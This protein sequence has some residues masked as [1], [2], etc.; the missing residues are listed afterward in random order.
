MRER[1]EEKRGYTVDYTGSARCVKR[2]AWHAVTESWISL[3]KYKKVGL[4]GQQGFTT[5]P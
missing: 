4:Q 3:W 1:R 2:K 5:P